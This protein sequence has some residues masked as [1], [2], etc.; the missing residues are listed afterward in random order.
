ML[1]YDYWKWFL[2]EGEICLES[3]DRQRVGV[4]QDA[5]AR[6]G[7]KV[8]LAAIDVDEIGEA[9]YEYERDD[10]NNPQMEEVEQTDTSMSGLG[11]L[12]GKTMVDFD[13]VCIDKKSLIQEDFFMSMELTS[14]DYLRRNGAWI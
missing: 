10:L 3:V 13:Q 12:D 6:R 5:A 9:Q 4:L 14:Q 7:F 8:G 11:F 1:Q 2:K